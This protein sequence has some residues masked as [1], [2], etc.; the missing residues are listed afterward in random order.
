MSNRMPPLDP[1]TLHVYPIGDLVAHNTSGG[2]CVCGTI[3][4]PAPRTDGSMGW[5]HIHHSLD[6]RERREPKC[7]SGTAGTA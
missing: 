5:L 6:G 2:D 3:T 7:F 4:E 1:D